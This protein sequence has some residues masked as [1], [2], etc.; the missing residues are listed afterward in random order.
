MIASSLHVRPCA[1][2]QDYIQGMLSSWK[3]PALQEKPLRSPQRVGGAE[4]PR[5]MQRPK[6][7]Y[8]FLGV[9]EVHVQRN[10]CVVM[11]QR[12]KG[13]ARWAASFYTCKG[14]KMAL[15]WYF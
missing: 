15:I 1:P 5:G 6:Q 10:A 7:S 13:V 12:L 8:E 4:L 11:A 9:K 2:L 3:L 14:V